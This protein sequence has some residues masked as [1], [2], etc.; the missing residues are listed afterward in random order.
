M[1]PYQRKLTYITQL[2]TNE[3]W[4][5]INTFFKADVRGIIW[6]LRDYASKYT[7]NKEDVVRRVAASL[8]ILQGYGGTTYYRYTPGVRKTNIRL[9]KKK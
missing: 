3:N 1:T 2:L 6:E 5:E 4:E 8:L 9:V 7:P